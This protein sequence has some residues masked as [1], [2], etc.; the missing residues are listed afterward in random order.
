MDDNLNW[1]T[2]L[3]QAFLNQQQDVMD[4]IQR[5]RQ[6]AYNLS[7]LQSTPQQQVIDDGGD[8]EIVPADPQVIYVPVYQP[9]QVYYQTG[10]GSPFISFGIGFPIGLWLDCDFDWGHHNIIVWGHDHPRPSNWWH[11][12]PRQRNMGNTTVWHHGNY[13]GAVGV[14]RGDRGYGVPHNQPVV[15]TVGR[16]VSDSAAPRRTPAPAARPEAPAT[17]ASMPVARPTVTTVSRSVSDS[18]APRRTPAPA[19]R[20]E[21][22]ATRASMPVARTTPAPVQH[23]QPV[24]R[25]ASTGAFIGIQSSH[26]TRTYSNRGQQSMQTTTHSAPASRPAPVSR[27]APSSGG[28]GGGGGGGSH[29]SNSPQKH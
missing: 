22:P 21:A 5:L 25:P 24:S 9:D 20:P 8:I 2:D 11:E 12:P 14:N 1:T 10:Y 29:N 17:R 16:S 27:P 13:P 7:N 15:A 6:S 18:A 3:G 19:A 23:S 4:S 28:G 26:D